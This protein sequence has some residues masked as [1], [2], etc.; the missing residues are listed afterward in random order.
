MLFDMFLGIVDKLLSNLGRLCVWTHY[1]LQVVT[2][3][4]ALKKNNQKKKTRIHKNVVPIGKEI[5]L[6]YP[7]SPPFNFT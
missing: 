1:K 5:M 6:L 3:Q 4:S 7:M 2:S